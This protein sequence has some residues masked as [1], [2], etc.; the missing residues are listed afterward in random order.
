VRA[1]R[2]KLVIVAADHG[3]NFGEDGLYFE[4]GPNAHNAST[5]IPLLISAPDL[6]ARHDHE[7]ISL[8]DVLP[9]LL[10]YLRIDR[11]EMEFDGKSHICR[12]RG[13]DTEQCKDSRQYVFL[14]SASSLALKNFKT[15]HSGRA[16][17]LHCLNDVRYS[18]CQKPGGPARLHDHIVDPHLETDL[19]KAHPDVYKRLLEYRRLWKPEEIREQAILDGKFKLVRYPVLSGGYEERAFRIDR[20]PYSSTDIMDSM[21]KSTLE[22]M[23]RKLDEWSANLPDP[24]PRGERDEQTIEEL[25]ALGYVD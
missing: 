8:E 19:S 21:P 2:E 7:P 10:D 15:I 6:P 11:G 4:H 16:K 20:D 9:T 5:R 17:H 22:Q 25:R 13:G 3:E 1:D 18:L 12:L 14:E 24:I 23:R